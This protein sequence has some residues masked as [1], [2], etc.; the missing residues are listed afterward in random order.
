MT[1][2]SRVQP[3]LNPPS[4]SVSDLSKSIS[5]NHTR[6]TRNVAVNNQLCILTREA[7]YLKSPHANVLL[8]VTALGIKP[9]ALCM[10]HKHYLSPTLTVPYVNFTVF[11]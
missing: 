5:F 6:S 2:P 11:Y 7:G 10:L 3:L 4:S 1:K 9:R 8:F